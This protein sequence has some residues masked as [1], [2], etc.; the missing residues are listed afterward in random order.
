MARA[1]G[2]SLSDPTRMRAG[3]NGSR[4]TRWQIYVPSKRHWSDA[5]KPG[6]VARYE[7]GVPVRHIG[8]SVSNL[9][10]DVEL[11]PHP[12]PPEA[13]LSEKARRALGM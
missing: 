3:H 9:S 10:V 11:R 1:I 8:P 6:S 2:S 4:D 13:E 5:Q 7:D 12:R